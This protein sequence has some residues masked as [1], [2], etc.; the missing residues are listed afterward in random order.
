[1]RGH[2]IQK[3]YYKWSN[4]CCSNERFLLTNVFMCSYHQPTTYGVACPL[5][6]LLTQH[7]SFLRN[8]SF[9]FYRVQVPNHFDPYPLKQVHI[10]AHDHL[11]QPT[12]T[13]KLIIS[14]PLTA[15]FW[16]IIH[17]RNNYTA[18]IHLTHCTFSQH[19]FAIIAYCFSSRK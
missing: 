5:P 8:L 4:T 10:I 6:T 11:A 3:L 19:S 12:G 13:V 18:Q 2:I 15:L 16:K 1:M 14:L 9:L 7:P 17:S